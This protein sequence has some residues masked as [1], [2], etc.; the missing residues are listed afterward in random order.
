[1][2]GY[3]VYYELIPETFVPGKRLG[4]HIRHDS[5]SRGYPYRAVNPTAALKTT[6]IERYIAILN[7]G[8][9]GDC[10]ENA[11]VGACGT[12]QIYLDLDVEQ[13]NSLNEI[14]AVSMYS[15]E[16]VLLG[17][18]PYPPNDDG[19]DGL[20]A[21]Q[22][23]KTHGLISGYTHCTTLNDVLEAVNDGNQ[24]MIGSNWYDSMDNPTSSGLV[25]I[26]PNAVVRGGHEYL[27]RG[28]NVESQLVFLDNSWGDEWGL[29]GSFE[30]SW[31]T[32]DRLLSEQGDGTV[33]A[34]INQ[35][36]PVPVVTS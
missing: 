6:L 9:V 19:G 2:T 17:Y 36:K 18:G 29:K 23:M 8:T 5:R 7:Q 15:D 33:P 22:V 21:C 25:S 13:R 34:G 26:S 11:G 20:A 27:A 28:I 32:L 30:Y 35:P 31:D 1:M 16:E 14:L 12:G 3:T 4:R 24:V 10:T